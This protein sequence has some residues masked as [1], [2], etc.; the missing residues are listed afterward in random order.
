[1]LSGLMSEEWTGF[2]SMETKRKLQEEPMRIG[3]KVWNCG[4]F[5]YE[6]GQRELV[7]NIG[8]R[9]SFPMDD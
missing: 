3:F 2:F 1:M 7:K 6:K 5:G 4:V 9:E 8:R